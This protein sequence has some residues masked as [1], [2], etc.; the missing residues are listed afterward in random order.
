[1]DAKAMTMLAIRGGT[2]YVGQHDFPFRLQ[3]AVAMFCS[4]GRTR[5]Q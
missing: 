4:H 3:R 5:T 1:M 2:E